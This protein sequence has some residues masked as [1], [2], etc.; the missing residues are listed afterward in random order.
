MLKLRLCSRFSPLPLCPFA[1]LIADLT[2]LIASLP[3][4]SLP[5][6]SLSA[7]PQRPPRS[8]S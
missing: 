2:C 8:L 1:C 7:L 5:S 6:S 4:S 3:A